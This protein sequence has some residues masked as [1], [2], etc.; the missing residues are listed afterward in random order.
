MQHSIIVASPLMQMRLVMVVKMA[1]T[2][3]IR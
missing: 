3:V 1:M 2:M